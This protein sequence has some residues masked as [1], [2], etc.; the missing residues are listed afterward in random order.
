MQEPSSA[1]S[2]T[3]RPLAAPIARALR[4]VSGAFDG[5]IDSSVD[6]AAVGLGQLERGLE[7]VFI[8]AVDDRGHGATVQP[9][10]RTQPLAR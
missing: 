4:I 6:L 3:R 5:A 10:V 9:A 8:V 7:R 1:G 2:V